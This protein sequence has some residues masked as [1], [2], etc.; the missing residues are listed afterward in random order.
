MLGRCICIMR[1]LSLASGNSALVDGSRGIS[2]AVPEIAGLEPELEDHIEI[3]TS[4]QSST[5]G[6]R[7]DI[8]QWFRSGCHAAHGTR[9]TAH[10]REDRASG[11]Q[12]V[13][14]S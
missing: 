11:R 10:R 8:A 14:A 12:Q 7:G 13:K 6:H 1:V 4:I 3:C 2:Q 9:R 5:N